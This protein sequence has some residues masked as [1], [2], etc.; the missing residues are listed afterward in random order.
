MLLLQAGLTLLT[1]AMIHSGNSPANRLILGIFSTGVGLAVI[2]LASHS[3]PFS[4][5][6]S[7][8]PAVLLQ[9]MPEAA[10]GP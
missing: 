3:S 5:E 4:G 7:V 6:I 9:V 10:N 2:L 1:I 8:S